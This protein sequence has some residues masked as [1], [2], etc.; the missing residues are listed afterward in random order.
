MTRLATHRSR[1]KY[2]AKKTRRDGHIFDSLAEADH[3]IVLKARQRD[4]EIT[5]LR[6]QPKFILLEAFTDSSGKRQRP[7]TYTADFA[8]DEAGDSVV[9]EVKGMETRDWII[10]KKLF[11][12][13]YPQYRLEIVK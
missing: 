7:I 9:V 8:Y 5:N 3:Y 10:R 11:L 6:L 4:G 2:N 12:Q 13:R 1:N